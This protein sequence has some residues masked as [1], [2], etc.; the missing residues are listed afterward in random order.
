L[1]KQ[2]LLNTYPWATLLISRRP[3]LQFGAGHECVV[4]LSPRQRN[5]Y[6]LSARHRKICNNIAAVSTVSRGEQAGQLREKVG[7]QS[8]HVAFWR[9]KKLLLPSTRELRQAGCTGPWT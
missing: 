7:T 8:I 9:G 5:A 4:G 1:K 3:F 2:G 6:F